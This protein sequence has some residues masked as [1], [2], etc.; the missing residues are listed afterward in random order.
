MNESRHGI[1]RALD[2][3]TLLVAIAGDVACGACTQRGAC[4]GRPLPLLRVPLASIGSGAAP[5]VGTPVVLE[6]AMPLVRAALLGYL[7]PVL[8][9]IAGAAI[10]QVGGPPVAAWLGAQAPA[11]VAGDLGAALGAVAGFAGSL[12]LLRRRDRPL[13]CRVESPSGL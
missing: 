5:P 11:S 9:L 4:T 13:R 12:L 6:E 1:V 3:D 8:A 10:G 7:A 2:G